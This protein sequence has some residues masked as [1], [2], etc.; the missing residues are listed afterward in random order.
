[1]NITLFISSLTGGGAER[2]MAEMANLFARYGHN[3]SLV[4]YS[5]LDDDYE[6]SNSVMRF[7][8]GEG[9]GTVLKWFAILKYFLKNNDDG[10]ISFLPG[11]TRFVILS[12]LLRR[13]KQYRIIAGERAVILTP[14]RVQMQMINH[15][16]K[17]ADYIVANSYTQARQI[18]EFNNDLSRKT[19]TI[20]NYADLRKYSVVQVKPSSVLRILITS[21]YRPEKNCL[22]FLRMLNILVHKT[23][24]PFRV[25]WYGRIYPEV[26]ETAHKY[27]LDNSLMHI[28]QLND[29]VDD[30]QKLL[31]KADVVCLPSLTEGFSN[32]ISEAICMGLPVLASDV[33]DNSLMV[34]DGVNGFLFDPNDIDDMCAA[35]IK[36]LN[37]SYKERVSMGRNSREIAEK[38]F[39]EE[40]FVNQYISLMR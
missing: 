28:I 20:I 27:I 31:N 39:D 21:H 9:K 37:L 22:N 10:V 26:Y 17:Y 16:Y 34:H 14:S 35:F 25:E 2:Q 24:I 33:S 29:R 6:V 7:R 1:M 23:D 4:T 38:I 15:L 11:C 18:V 32:S 3:V 12:S 19:L 13:R 8:L 5:D 36:F 30:V 40:K